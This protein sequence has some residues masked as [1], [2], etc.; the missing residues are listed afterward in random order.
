MTEKAQRHT[1][2]YYMHTHTHFPPN[3]KSIHNISVVE[4]KHLFELSKEFI[5][6]LFLKMSCWC[7]TRSSL[8][9]S[10]KTT[11]ICL[12]LVL[13]W[14]DWN[15]LFDASFSGIWITCS[16]E[17]G[18]ATKL[19]VASE[20]QCLTL[21]LNFHYSEYHNYP[22]NTLYVCTQREEKGRNV[23]SEVLIISV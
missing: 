18:C 10:M 12:H 8:K 4:K 14:R 21:C 5:Y 17:C 3:H 1:K 20:K 19:D 13:F 22:S 2:I 16:V 15:T 11:K 6:F 7:L 23:R 9:R